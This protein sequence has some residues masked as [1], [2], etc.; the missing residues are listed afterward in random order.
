VLGYVP[1]LLAYNAINGYP[2]PAAHVSRKMTWYAP[3]ALQVL[4]SPGHGF[5]F[6]TPLAVLAIAGL[7]LLKD[8]WIALC[9]LIMVAS[10]VYVAGSVESWTVAGA[11]GQRR[12]VCLTVVLVVGLTSLWRGV[13]ERVVHVGSGL[14]Y[15]TTTVIALCVWW[16][17]A[18]MAQFA[19][20][21]MDRQRL[22]P[23]RNAYHAFVTLPLAAP[24]LAYRYLTDRDSFYEP[25]SGGTNR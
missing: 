2:G 20:R 11:F 4:A 15:A 6:W 16:N 7:F 12:F 3:H 19:T 22:E 18:L 8:R 10:Q 13:G 5:F 9:L 14:K 21:L 23:A 25:R 17:I 24:S 1:Q